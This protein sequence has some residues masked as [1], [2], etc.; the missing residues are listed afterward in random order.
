V[1][2]TP[3][4]MV[5]SLF[6]GMGVPTTAKYIILATL[7]APALVSMG[8]P[9]LPAHLFI[10]YF[11]TDADITPPVGLAS[12]AAAGIAGA[13]PLKTGW[14]AFKMG[15]TAYIV[16]YLIIYRP[17]IILAAPLHEILFAFVT[18]LIGGAVL[19]AAMQGYFIRRM[20]VWHR[21]MAGAGA[22]LLLD[23]HIYMDFIG[24]ALVLFIVFLERKAKR[25]ET[26]EATT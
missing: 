20:P 22:I 16:P 9:L 15:I 24:A 14:E 3:L 2:S 6:L 10:L 1:E 7:V 11:G 13:D 26:L 25:R 18:I 5:A 8:A 23:P 12:Y 17:A 4:T 19:G 21:L